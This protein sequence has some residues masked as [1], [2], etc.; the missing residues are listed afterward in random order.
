[1]ASFGRDCPKA[2]DVKILGFVRLPLIRAQG[3]LV[4]TDH[5]GDSLHSP[6]S[7]VGQQAFSPD[8]N[9]MT[10][11]KV[12]SSSVSRLSICQCDA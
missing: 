11:R 9:F 4:R 6:E 10:Y 7:P 1:M 8:A 3:E 2:L 12:A 5:L